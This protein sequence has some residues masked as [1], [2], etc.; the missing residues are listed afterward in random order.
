MGMEEGNQK[1]QSSMSV[2]AQSFSHVWLFETPW[3]LACQT[4]LFM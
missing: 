1:L 4:P 3:T 2:H